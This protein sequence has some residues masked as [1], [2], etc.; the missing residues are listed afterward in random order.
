MVR[1]RF[2]NRI[3]LSEAFEDVCRNPYGP[4]V[5]QF[6]MHAPSHEITLVPKEDGSP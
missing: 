3:L 6:T 4:S 2:G 5:K 1:V